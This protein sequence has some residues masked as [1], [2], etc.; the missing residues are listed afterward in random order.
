M[1]HIHTYALNAHINAY[2]HTHRGTIDTHRQTHTVLSSSQCFFI[3]EQP[4]CNLKHTF[5]HVTSI[6]RQRRCRKTSHIPLA[7]SFS[8]YQDR[9]LSAHPPLT[10][11]FSFVFLLFLLLH[12]FPLSP[13]LQIHLSFPV[14][15]SSS[16]LPSSSV[17]WVVCFKLAVQILSLF[18][19]MLHHLSLK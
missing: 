2:I 3:I 7:A 13:F 11:H 18:T 4:W 16:F 19:P 17:P 9:R 6:H 10:F 8:L 15:L 5:W 14:P 12:L 1:E